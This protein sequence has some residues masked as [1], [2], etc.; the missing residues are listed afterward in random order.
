VVAP[1]SNNDRVLVTVL[2]G[3][4][5]PTYRELRD[6]IFHPNSEAYLAPVEED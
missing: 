5:L 1:G 3:S 4:E 2:P 6:E